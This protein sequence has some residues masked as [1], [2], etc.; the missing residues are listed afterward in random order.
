[1]IDFERNLVFVHIPRTG[2]SSIM[3]AFGRTP[4]PQVYERQLYEKHLPVSRLRAKCAG[5]WESMHRFSFVRDPYDR[6]VS[7]YFQQSFRHINYHAGASMAEFLAHYRS[8]LLPWE[9]GVQQSDY[10]DTADEIEI[11]RYEERAAVLLGLADRY[12]V[13]GLPTHRSEPVL[14]PGLNARQRADDG[15]SI[16]D[17]FD[18][19]ALEAMQRLFPDDLKQFSWPAG[20]RKPTAAKPQP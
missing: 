9:H 18:A 6:A 16:A 13:P 4:Y 20:E 15:R 8:A 12:A 3:Q 17:Y 5:H 11:Y 19:D 14:V 2:G 7:L 10:F 1:M